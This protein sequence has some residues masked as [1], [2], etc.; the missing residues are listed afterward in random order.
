MYALP[1]RHWHTSAGPK[2][3]L[4]GEKAKFEEVSNAGLNVAKNLPLQSGA[5]T[6]SL[7]VAALVHLVM[8]INLICSGTGYFLYL[9]G[10]ILDARFKY[11]VNVVASNI[12]TVIF[13]RYVVFARSS[14][15]PSQLMF[16]H[17]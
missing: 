11:G 1:K 12:H 16:N 4:S 5:P 3:A 10:G 13:A 8:F 17:L 15:V 6:S 2:P 7:F 9:L 14:F